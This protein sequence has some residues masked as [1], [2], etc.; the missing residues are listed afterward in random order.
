MVASAERQVEFESA[1]ADHPDILDTIR[2]Q[3][4]GDRRHARQV[5]EVLLNQLDEARK[6]VERLSA[7]ALTGFDD[8]HN[9]L[10]CAAELQVAEADLDAAERRFREVEDL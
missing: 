7:A 6:R 9:A 2:E 1:P 10:R 3:C 5:K 8:T 4:R